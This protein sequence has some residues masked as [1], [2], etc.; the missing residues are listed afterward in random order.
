MTMG[1]YKIENKVNGKIYIGSSKNIE[2]RWKKHKYDLRSNNHHSEHMQNAWNKYGKEN[3]IF[4]I[5]EEI[6]D[7]NILIEREQYWI[8]A[9]KSYNI[10]IGYNIAYRAGVPS[11]QELICKVF[12]VKNR[13]ML[14][15]KEYTKNE[16]IFL[17]SMIPFLSVPRNEIKINYKYPTQIELMKIV[18][19]SKPTYLSTIRQLKEKNIIHISNTKQGIIII[20]NPNLFILNRDIDNN[21]FDLFK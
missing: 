7:E 16:R 3:F 5:I 13:M 15:N 11:N 1:I 8:N 21:I 4:K 6:R 12:A 2:N 9:L 20:V 18:D 19:M 10:D 14:L 17:F